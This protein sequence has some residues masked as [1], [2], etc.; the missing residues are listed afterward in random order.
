MK[1]QCIFA[2]II[3]TNGF[4]KPTLVS[5]LVD[6]DKRSVLI[7]DPDGGEKAWDKYPEIHREQIQYMTNH[8]C[9]LIAPEVDDIE[10]FKK[11]KNDYFEVF[12]K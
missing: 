2:I 5:I 9:K 4:G 10:A 7:A 6:K 3:G 12:T 8:K 11:F 1:R